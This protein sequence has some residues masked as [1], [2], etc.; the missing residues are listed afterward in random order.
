[1]TRREA[2]VQALK[3]RVRRL[4][5]RCRQASREARSDKPWRLFWILERRITRLEKRER[6]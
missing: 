1:M 2:Q 3:A 6:T 5:A 4:E